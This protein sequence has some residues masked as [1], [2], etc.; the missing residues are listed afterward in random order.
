MVLINVDRALAWCNLSPLL[1]TL[2][3]SLLELATIFA[4]FVDL[5]AVE[6]SPDKSTVQWD[7][8]LVCE[9]SFRDDERLHDLK[10]ACCRRNN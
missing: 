9:C 4:F 7:L 8:A 3:T 6:V 5:A 10:T 2:L 1:M